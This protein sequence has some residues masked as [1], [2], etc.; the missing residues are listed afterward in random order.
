MKFSNRVKPV[1]GNKVT[2]RNNITLIENKKVLTSEVELALLI[3][4]LLILFPS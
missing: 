2:T 4:I 1:Y 3:S